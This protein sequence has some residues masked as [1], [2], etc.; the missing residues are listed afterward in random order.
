MNFYAGI[1]GGG[2]K[3]KVVCVTEKGE[4]AKLFGPFNLNSI[5]AERFSQLLRE[6]GDY[7]SSIGSCQALC[8]G[9]AGV[10]NST[11]VQ[12]VTD[13]MNVC[14]IHNWK[15]VGD[16]EIALTGALD[17]AP[18]IALIAG[19]GSICFGRAEDG[20][21]A[22]SGGWG[23]L[24]GDEG[25]GYALGRDALAAVARAFDGYG[26]KT[27]LTALLVSQLELSTQREIISYTYG[28]DK[29]RVA[30]LS[31][32]VEQA[33]REGDEVARS[34]IRKNAKEMAALVAAVEQRLHLG[35]TQVAMLGGML[36]N[37]TMLRAE[38]KRVMAGL[39][40]RITCVAPN[41]DAAEGA[42]MMAK[43][44]L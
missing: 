8:I 36:E 26:E 15:L 33:A 40:P 30:A 25:S 32:L 34:I 35:E 29:S 13:A 41:H 23:H 4:E 24:I 38:F 3:T 20:T 18:G 31:R 21:T 5:G 9:S 22:R 12:M 43:A 10:S 27:A 44:M 14:G 6:I 42:V 2:T 39:C 11:M 7:L 1:D 19:T 17:G 16:Q 37:D 28:G